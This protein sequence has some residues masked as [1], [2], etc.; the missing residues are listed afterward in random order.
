[1]GDP[2]KQRKK[3]SKPNHP[4]EKERIDAEK[5]LLK[6][7]GLKN[8]KEIWK[9]V[10]FIKNLKDLSKRLSSRDTEQSKKEQEQVL[11]R[12]VRLGVLSSE[13]TISDVLGLTTDSILERRL[14]TVLFKKGFARTVSQA[15]QMI[16]HGHIA[17]DGKKITFPSYQTKLAEE[18]TITYTPSSNFQNA[19]HP[20]LKLETQKAEIIEDTK[21]V[22]PKKKAVKAK[23]VEKVEKTEKTDV[24]EVT[25]KKEEV[26]QEESK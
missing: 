21:V 18:A 19:D 10:S 5:E 12:L 6:Q 26:Q 14:Q 15:R 2:K 17:I 24:V 1:M 7:F 9:A 3:Y 23:T 13:S 25:E 8:K 11:G 22:E 20:E 4:W 16:V